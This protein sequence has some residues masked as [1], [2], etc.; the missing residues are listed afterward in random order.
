ML[1]GTC[2]VQQLGHYLHSADNHPHRS[3]LSSHGSRYRRSKSS[4][5]PF[6]ASTSR[7]RSSARRSRSGS[8]SVRV[9]HRRTRVAPR[10]GRGHGR[11]S[12]ELMGLTSGAVTRVIDRLEQAGYVRR[13]TDPSRP[14]AGH[15]RGR[16]RARRRPSRASSTR[17]SARPR[18]RSTA[19]PPSSWRSSTTSWAGWPTS[20][21]PSR[22]RLRTT[23]E[24]GPRGAQW[25]SEH[26]AP[27]AGLTAAR[28]TFRSGA[29][30]IRL[31]GEA[32][33]D[34]AV[35]RPV[36]GATPQV[37]VRDGRVLVQYRG[38]PV[39]LAKARR[40]DRPQHGDR[41]DDRDRR[42]DRSGSRP[43]CA[44]SRCTVRP[45]RRHRAHPAR[46]R[47]AGAA[48]APSGSSAGAQ[49][50]A[51]SDRPVPSGCD[52]GGRLR[53]VE[54]E[55]RARREGRRGRR[56]RP[57][58]ELP[59]DDRYVVEVVGGSKSI[60]VRGAT[61]ADR[62]PGGSWISAGRRRSARSSRR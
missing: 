50:S 2:A 21:K 44:R 42:R 19:T 24:D 49:P 7:A 22:A 47:R 57:R 17:S 12:S 8:V 37:R 9:R 55:A 15:R 45:D 59:R 26:A 33:R 56:S 62:Q 10:H 35:P 29:Q 46:A 3:R 54:L 23:A 31:S 40:D 11:R 16:P 43:T 53:P 61:P 60:E 30:E 48:R 14:P 39:R 4:F 52:L 18:A 58:L 6:A 34:R 32:A 38:H 27:S 25:P 28:L 13:T 41:L 1:G 5:E 20:P 36:R 51:S